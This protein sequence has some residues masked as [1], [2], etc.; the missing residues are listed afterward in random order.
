MLEQKFNWTTATWEEAF[1]EAQQYVDGLGCGID[2]GILETVVALNLL[3]FRSTAS[4]EGHLDHGHA[5]PW[6][7]FD[8][9]GPLP[10]GYDEAVIYH[11]DL[12]P[13]EQEAASER[14]LA[15]INAYHTENHLYTRLT[16][17]LD[18]YYEM[19]SAIPDEQRLMLWTIHLG[20]YRLLPASGFQEKAWPEEERADRLA[21]CQA[22]MRDVTRY[23]KERL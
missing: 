5:Y 1:A 16:A 11:E 10:A 15:M 19:H 18:A 23:F 12:S 20:W 2:Q 22:E 21:Q 7:D 9:D 13:E 3:G 6:V 17:L 4:C 14:F 8:V